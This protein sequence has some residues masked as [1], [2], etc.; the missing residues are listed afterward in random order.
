MKPLINDSKIQELP[1]RA[2]VV[3]KCTIFG[4]LQN[5]TQLER[6]TSWSFLNLTCNTDINN[7]TAVLRY[8]LAVGARLVGSIPIVGLEGMLNCRLVSARQHPLPF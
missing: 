2:R 8:P 5:G 6:G 1:P 4:A 7:S 3:S